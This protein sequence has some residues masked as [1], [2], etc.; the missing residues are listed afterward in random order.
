MN[1][2]SPEFITLSCPSCGGKLEITPDMDRFACAFCGREHIVKRTN[3]T[4]SLSPVVEAIHHVRIGVDKTAAELAIVRLQKEISEL[5]EQKQ[6][7]LKDKPSSSVQGWAIAALVFG[8]LSVTVAAWNLLI[9]PT[10]TFPKGDFASV[11][12]FGSILLVFGLIPI[13]SWRNKKWQWKQSVEP[14]LNALSMQIAKIQSELERNRN[15]VSSEFL[16][17]GG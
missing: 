12:C 17:N 14:Q 1:P 6:K 8:S 3:S 11:L 9:G 16:R 10:K 15:I 5:Q 13:L 7:L 4:I 2:N